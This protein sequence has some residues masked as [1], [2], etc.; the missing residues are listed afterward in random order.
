MLS[1]AALWLSFYLFTFCICACVL[2]CSS[3][4]LFH[5]SSVHIRPIKLPLSIEDDKVEVKCSATHTNEHTLKQCTSIICQLVHRFISFRNM[6]RSRKKY[7]RPIVWVACKQ[8]ELDCSYYFSLH[9]SNFMVKI[10]QKSKLWTLQYQIQQSPSQLQ[11]QFRSKFMKS[12][13]T[14]IWTF[15]K[16]KIM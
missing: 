13:S 10:H 2:F 6:N 5:S 15:Q 9:P 16:H 11:F 14:F 3:L 1:P 12:L 7:E 4:F 8:L